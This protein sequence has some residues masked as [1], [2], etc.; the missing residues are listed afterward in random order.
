MQRNYSQFTIL[1]VSCMISKQWMLIDSR[2]Y[3][4]YSGHLRSRKP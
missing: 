4:N 2:K 1:N 3:V